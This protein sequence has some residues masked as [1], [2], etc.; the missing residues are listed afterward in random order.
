MKQVVKHSL[1]AAMVVAALGAS[2]INV[3]ALAPSIDIYGDQPYSIA[4]GDG[5]KVEEGTHNSS[6]GTPIPNVGGVAIGRGATVTGS[7]FSGSA[8]IGEDSYNDRGALIAGYAPITG[9]GYTRDQ[10]NAATLTTRGSVS[11]APD[12]GSRQLTGVAAGSVD[13]DAV[14]VRQM[15]DMRIYATYTAGD[16]V[17]ITE[18]HVVSAKD[19]VATVTAGN[20]IV[21]TDT[22]NGNDNHNYAVAVDPNLI[23]TIDQTKD[24]SLNNESAIRNVAAITQENVG[25]LNDVTSKVND[26]TSKMNITPFQ[27]HPIRAWEPHDTRFESQ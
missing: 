26:N 23:Q 16:N 7:A 5:A 1:Q 18:D 24:R 12:K 13:T 3:F 20:G 4:I 27:S 17:T 25:R 15:K 10:Y 11:F 2:S 9:K 21:V 6:T 8:A 19:S 14:N 22:D